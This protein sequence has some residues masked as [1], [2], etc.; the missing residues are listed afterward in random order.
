MGVVGGGS[1]GGRVFIDAAIDNA[2]DRLLLFQKQ[3]GSHRDWV[4]NQGKIVDS[5]AGFGRIVID[6]DPLG[7]DDGQTFSNQRLV[8][9]SG[10]FRSDMVGSRIV[11]DGMERTVTVFTSAI[12]IEVSGDALLTAT[13]R[14]FS[15]DG[16]IIDGPHTI[17]GTSLA[18]FANEVIHTTPSEMVIT[19]N[20]LNTPVVRN[21]VTLSDDQGRTGMDDG[22]D[23]PGNIVYGGSGGTL[24]GDL[25]YSDG[26]FTVNAAGG[27]ID[28]CLATYDQEVPVV[29]DSRTVDAAPGAVRLRWVQG[30]RR[31]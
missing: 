5:R 23:P 28:T 10:F 8:S 22:S 9:V 21:S 1:A 3:V 7:A 11:I 14:T 31:T 25:V 18:H 24:Q 29:F 17:G 13:G 12:E 2:A 30:G 26:G 6:V 19:G 27:N 15:V 20:F 16:G 4:P